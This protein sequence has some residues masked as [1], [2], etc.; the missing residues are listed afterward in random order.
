[1]ILQ[2][3]TEQPPLQILLADDDL[4]DRFFFEK[5][6]GEIPIPTNLTIVNDGESLMKY[7]A[8]HSMELPDLLFLDLSMPRKN[9]FECLIEIRDDQ[10]LKDLHV[11]VFSTSF[12]RDHDYEKRMI[13]MLVDIGAQDFITKPNNPEKL[14]AVIE[15]LLIK[16]AGLHPKNNQSFQKK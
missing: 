3:S 15:P 11:V 2:Y 5:A 10:K 7:L 1:M 13:K 6:L 14:K 16:W 12:P 4:D 8:A 9:G